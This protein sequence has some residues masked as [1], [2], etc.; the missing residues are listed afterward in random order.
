MSEWAEVEKLEQV[1]KMGLDLAEFTIGLRFDDLPAS[2]AHQAKRVLLEGISWPFLGGRRPEGRRLHRYLNSVPDGR[3][4]VAGRQRGLAP[5]WAA[6][7]NGALSQVQDCNDGQRVASVY[8]GSFH[9]G[10]VVVPVALAACRAANRSGRDLL[11]AIVAGY[12]VAGRVRGLEPRPPTTAYAGATVAARLHGL[13][14]ETA[15]SAMGIAGHLASPIPDETPFDVTFL[16]VGNVARLAMEATDLAREGLTG[17][18]LL[19]DARLAQR[20]ADGG[21][22]E[23]FRIMHIY[24]KPYLGCRL[25]HGAID[26]GIELL[27]VLDWRE[28]QRIRVR[29]VPEAHYVCGYADPGAYYRTAQLS[30]A[31]CLAAVL[32]DGELEEAQF[33]DERIGSADVQALQHRIEVVTDESL[34]ADYPHDG[35]PTVMEVTSRDG[36]IHRRDSHFDLGEPENPLN[37]EE[38]V[39]KFHRWAGPSLPGDSADR[40]VETVLGLD[41]TD[42]PE[43]LFELLR[44]HRPEAHPAA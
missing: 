34:N 28:I 43:P 16:T 41:A 7:A 9:P 17:P 29:V 20:L 23:T 30:L 39:E 44:H 19:D 40:L 3:C 36:R 5:G 27:R 11:T 18:P 31:Y 32:I 4:S 8:G 15:L 35:R 13:D 22:G 33:T 10:R 2:V 21:I 6:F 24:M 38:L 26:G 12:E 14:P 1:P 42:N 37:D 25:V